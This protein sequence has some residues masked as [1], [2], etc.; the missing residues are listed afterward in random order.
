MLRPHSEL[1]AGYLF[2]FV[3]S[4]D[5]IRNLSD[6]VKGSL[7]PAVSDQQVRAQKIPLPPLAEQQRIAA[8]LREQLAV[9]EAARQAAKAQLAAIEKLPAALL[10]EAFD[11]GAD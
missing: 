11:N 4:E 10:R 7:Y 6:L 9:A 8:R 1:D 5:F 2:A 3:Q